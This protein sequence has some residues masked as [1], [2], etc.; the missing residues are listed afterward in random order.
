[1]GRNL[2]ICT[3]V[4]AKTGR[5]PGAPGFRKTDRTR[6]SIRVIENDFPVDSRLKNVN[7]KLVEIVFREFKRNIDLVGIHLRDA[8]NMLVGSRQVDNDHVLAKA[9]LLL[10]SAALES[11]L[12]YLSGVALRLAE[13]QKGALSSPQLRYL[14]GI[15]EAID[16]NGKIISAPARQSLGERLQVVPTLLAHTIERDYMLKRRSAAFKKLLRTIARRDAIVHPRWDKYVPEVGWWEAAEAID[17]VELYLDSVSNALHPYLVGYF[18]LLYTI[19]GYDHHEVAV[20]H[21]TFGKRGPTREVSSMDR[22]GIAEV[23]SREWIDS[24]MLIHLA[25]GHDC[26]GDSDGSMLTRS[27]L[28]LLYSMLDA[29]LAVVAQWRMRE[30]GEKFEEAEIL[31]L[32]EYAVGVGHDGEVWIGEDHQSFKKRI[33]VV[34]AILSRRI[35][36]KE[37]SID[38][39]K[40]WG[41]DLAE[42]K[43]LRDRVM[44]SAFG[45]PLVRV[46]KAELVRSAKAVIAYFQE[47]ATKLPLTFEYMQVFLDRKVLSDVLL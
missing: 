31:F 20:G 2:L 23:L 15:T 42:G 7:Q 40:Q 28:I 41:K 13:A 8:R 1:M 6:E 30:K 18:S 24:L 29:Q 4:N 25:L 10:A 35:E 45:E 22:A 19:P 3:Q 44:H 27:A 14:R 38:L 34:P 33:K 47:L 16:E 11:N 12:V 17:A 26:E 36:K 46:S 39:S 5:E 43:A 37:E 9:A 21:R 32:N